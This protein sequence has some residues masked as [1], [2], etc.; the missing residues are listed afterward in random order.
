MTWLRIDDRFAEHEKVLGL[1]RSD[2]WT[3][4]ELLCYCARQSSDTVPPK[5]ADLIKHVTPAFLA[6]C[7]SVG[8][9][10]RDEDGFLHVHDWAVYN[11]RDL[12]AAARQQRYRNAQNTVTRNGR[13]TAAGRNESDAPRAATRA[14]PDPTPTPTTKG[15]DVCLEPNERPIQ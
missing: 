4:V 11:N 7:A 12:T 6:R 10:D 9:L 13:V 14:R 2:R 8:L 15:S 5:V 3:W 1:S